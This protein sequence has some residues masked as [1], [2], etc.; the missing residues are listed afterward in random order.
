MSLDLSVLAFTVIISI[1]TGMIFGLIPAIRQSRSQ[2]IDAL[3]LGASASISGFNPFRRQRTLGALVVAEIAMATMLF[4]GGAL[5]IHSFF[6]LSNVNA[7]FDPR[8]VLTFQIA[9]PPAAAR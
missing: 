8:G 3:R 7:G 6:K 1:L 9:L 5:L 4:I 2:P